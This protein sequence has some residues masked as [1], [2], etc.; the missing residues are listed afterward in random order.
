MK[1]RALRRL[2]AAMSLGV[3]FTGWEASSFAHPDPEHHAD[4]QPLPLFW[5]SIAGGK[6]VREDLEAPTE[7]FPPPPSR[8]SGPAL[9]ARQQPSGALSGRIVYFNM[10]H[11]WTADVPASAASD[12][13]TQRGNS[14]GVVEDYGNMDQG[15]LFAAYAWNAGATVVPVRPIGHQ[16]NEV[17]IDQDDAN[18]T[19]TGTWGNSTNT[20]AYQ[21]A[22]GSAAQTY[23]FATT[24]TGAATA[25]ARYSPNIPEAGYYPVYAWVLDGSDRVNQLYRVAHAGGVSESRVN[26]RRVGKGWVWLGSYWFEAGSQ[27]NQYVEISNVEEV[28]DA[29]TVVIADAVRFGNGMGSIARSTYG[30]SGFAREEEQLRYWAENAQAPASVYDSSSSDANDNV[31]GAPRYAAYMNRE[32]EGAIT[33]RVFISFHSNATGV[34]GGVTYSGGA[35]GL[36]NDENPG[37]TDSPNQ[38]DLALLLGR[39]I[40]DDMWGLSNSTGTDY[41]PLYGDWTSTTGHTYSADFAYGELRWDSINNEM[42]C[43]IIEV[44]F[45]DSTI[46]QLYLK[47]MLARRAIARSTCQGLIRYFNQFGGGPLAMPPDE[48]RNLR[49]LNAVNGQP[50]LVLN[51][52]APLQVASE[53]P[54][55]TPGNI[56]GD[57]PTGYKVYASSNGRD[58]QLLA[59]LGNVTTYTTTGLANEAT[60][61]FYVT[62]TNAGGESLPSNVS[63]GRV[64]SARPPVLI[65]DGFDRADQ[66]IALNETVSVPNRSNLGTFQRV[67]SHR[68]NNFSYVVEHGE[69]MANGAEPR[70]F[71]AVPNDAV[72]AGQVSLANYD[73]VVWILGRESENAAGATAF[74]ATERTAV[75]NFLNGG[76]NLFLSGTDWAYDLGRVGQPAAETTFT[77]STLR[78][79]YVGDN[80]NTYAVDGSVAGIFTGL[81]LSLSD[82]DGPVYDARSPD[83]LGAGAGAT[84]A[85]TYTGGNG[86]NAAIVYDGTPATGRVIALGFPFEAID[87]AATRTEVMARA[88]T[89]FQTPGSTNTPPQLSSPLAGIVVTRDAG[90]VVTNNFATVIDAEQDAGTVGISVAGAPVGLSASTS[91]VAGTISVTIE[92]ACTVAPGL[93]DVSLVATDDS[94]AVDSEPFTVTVDDCVACCDTPNRPYMTAGSGPRESIIDAAGVGAGS[95]PADYASLASAIVAINGTPLSGGDWTFLIRSNLTE[96]SNVALGQ[97][98]GGNRL[99][100]R[101]YPSTAATINFAPAT[102][103]TATGVPGHWVIGVNQLDEIN[104]TTGAPV[105]THNVTIDGSN[106]GGSLAITHTGTNA[107]PLISIAGNCDGLELKN[108]T[109]T[110]LVAL[111]FPGAIRTNCIDVGGGDL[112]PDNLLIENCIVSG[113]SASTAVSIRFDR[114]TGRGTLTTVTTD[115]NNVTVRNCTISQGSSAIFSA[116]AQGMVIEGNTINSAQTGTGTDGRG[117]MFFSTQSSGRTNVI[118]RNRLTVTAPTNSVSNGAYALYLEANGSSPTN[119]NVFEVYNNLITVQLTGTGTPSAGILAGIRGV[120]DNTDYRIWHNSIH[121]RQ[122]AVAYAGLDG[123]KAYGFGI[124]TATF[125]GVADVRNNLMRVNQSGAVGLYFAPASLAGSSSIE[126]DTNNIWLG[127]GASWGRRSGTE[128][129]LAT[130]RTFTLN[131]AAFDLASTGFDPRD[132]AGGTRATWV[133]DLDLK[134][135]PVPPQATI[136]ILGGPLA[137]AP[138]PTDIDNFTRNAATPFKG[139]DEW[140]VAD[141]FIDPADDSHDFGEVTVGQFADHTFTIVNRGTAMLT[142]NAATPSGSGE[143]VRIAPSSLPVNVPAGGSV[144]FTVR[145]TPTAGAKAASFSIATN[146]PWNGTL[147]LNVSG[148]GVVGTLEADSMRVY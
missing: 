4:E 1:R 138:V 33:D 76:G 145:F 6:D 26:H 96:T 78:A 3:L 35:D 25:T 64:H 140:D 11:G 29:G 24:T 101:P 15:A 16:K 102:A 62:A 47:D 57:A 74:D 109:V 121:L 92:A 68:I 31:G 55:T 28:G 119:R 117:I 85:M 123:S 129:S 66:S 77:N 40:N 75:T 18:V 98:T 23:R 58:F 38:F 54:A 49:V 122:P 111:A 144:A 132:N 112:T 7:T 125:A 39:E 120:T 67:I 63:G 135:N 21:V 50:D 14:G 69:A 114:L 60:R 17:V 143:F 56:G 82:F 105:A 86:G 71:D 108:L 103:Q 34:S 142:L 53:R 83:Q 127:A 91:N 45:H 139:A 5:S 131:G 126:T 32:I 48:P 46:D 93:Y 87:S 146:D 27:P 115:S 59:T 12:W 100:F 13:F 51:W 37:V 30:V 8:V 61:Y 42:D 52:T 97:D 124:T 9:N 110:S 106:A 134:F 36:Y 107:G 88:L 43:T 137:G 90:P 44:A 41:F 113:G 20:P 95:P 116:A 81:A 130:W 94:S 141:V 136:E 19:F 148:E 22:P 2:V 99:Y 73:T 79:T 118:R 10:G 147:V 65:V 104:N 133:S 72:I 80:A 84:V 89:F 128:A 70:N